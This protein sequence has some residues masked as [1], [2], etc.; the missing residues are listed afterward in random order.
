MPLSD[1][2]IKNAKP[3]DKLYRLFDGER[4]YVEVRPS[5]KKKWR[6]RVTLNGKPTMISL[7]DYPHV[8]LKDARVRRDEIMFDI[9][10]GDDPTRPAEAPKKTLTFAAVATEWLAI[11]EQEQRNQKA[12]YTMR[13]RIEKY[14]NPYIGDMLPDDVSAP[15]LLEVL[16]LIEDRGTLTTAHKTMSL[17]GQVFRYAI[18]T[19]QASRDPAADLRGALRRVDI[20]HYPSITKPKE[21][22]GLMRA[23][24]GYDGS[25]IGR[26]A[27]LVSAY[28]FVRP[29]ELRHMEWSEVDFAAREWRIQPE[30]MKAKRLH[31]VPLSQQVFDILT[32]L[33][34]YTGH[35]RYAFP[36]RRAP[37]G[38]VPM[39]NNTV[40][41][42]LRRLGY[43]KEEM[44]AHGFRSMASTQLNE[45]GLWPMDAI[46]R[47]LA[48][49]EGSSVRAAYNYAEHLP[50]RR[51]MMQWWA[52]WLD[53]V[54]I[55]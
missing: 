49:V 22:G 13:L 48:H 35:G 32:D 54:K 44:T 30:K 33:Y 52:D 47:Q 14:V 1:L 21:I 53:G 2:Q 28:T 26:Y 31:V 37:A 38:N 20:K 11:K 5:G 39:S 4:L 12:V 19:G 8:S 24:N 34:R 18:L 3:K 23:I 41:A 15:R 6:V 55:L 25:I 17:C 7:G 9:A 16:R 29:G 40:N 10:A 42:A 50:E 46:E 51:K 43:P 27:L 36:S 45:S